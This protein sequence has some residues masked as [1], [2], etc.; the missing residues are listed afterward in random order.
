MYRSISCEAASGHLSCENP[1]FATS[2]PSCLTGSTD[3]SLWGLVCKPRVRAHAKI[4]GK[5]TD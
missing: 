4:M 3:F 5:T 1:V 2:R